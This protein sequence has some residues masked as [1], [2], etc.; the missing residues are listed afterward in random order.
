LL[1][2]SIAAPFADGGAVLGMRPP[3]KAIQHITGTDST[4][5]KH[6]Q[7]VI[8]CCHAMPHL[9]LMVAL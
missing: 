4:C 7:F 9:L 8:A 6:R 2:H 3:E 1:P 5:L